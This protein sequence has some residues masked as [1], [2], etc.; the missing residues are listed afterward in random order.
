MIFL[1]S[2]LKRILWLI[3]LYQKD[4]V[5]YGNGEKD[6]SKNIIKMKKA[7]ELQEVSYLKVGIVSVDEI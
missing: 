6:I 1:N 4:Y 5:L 2:D 3:G 7:T